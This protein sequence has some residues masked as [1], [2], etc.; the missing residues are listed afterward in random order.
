M[1]SHIHTH[2]QVTLDTRQALQG[3]M[4]STAPRTGDT[5]VMLEAE[6]AAS[7]WRPHFMLLRGR[8]EAKLLSMADERHRAEERDE[9]QGA[10]LELRPGQP[11]NTSRGPPR[12][13]SCPGGVKRG[14]TSMVS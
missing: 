5:Y 7:L 2:L 13:Y 6:V 8:W 14:G 4:G 10:P 11:H 3:H 9:K 12:D 1:H